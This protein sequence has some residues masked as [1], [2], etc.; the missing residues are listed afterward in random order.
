MDHLQKKIE[1]LQ[2][3]RVDA[4]QIAKNKEERMKERIDE[5][6]ERLQQLQNEN[7]A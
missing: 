3:S 7:K 6:Q 4:S 2:Q 5:C 1:T